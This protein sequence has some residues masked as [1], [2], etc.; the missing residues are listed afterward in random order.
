[1]LVVGWG[2]GVGGCDVVDERGRR[3]TGRA[4]DGAGEGSSSEASK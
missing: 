2:V 4:T 1:M 3:R